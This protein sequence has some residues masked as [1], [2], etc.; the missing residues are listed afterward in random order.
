MEHV[1]NVFVKFATRVFLQFTSKF[2]SS[3]SLVRNLISSVQ[4]NIFASMTFWSGVKTDRCSVPLGEL[5]KWCPTE[6]R[7]PPNFILLSLTVI[8]LLCF[9]R[10]N[11]FVIFSIQNINLTK[12]NFIEQFIKFEHWYFF[13]ITSPCFSP[14]AACMRLIHL[15]GVTFFK[16]ILINVI[17]KFFFFLNV[18]LCY[19]Y[20]RVK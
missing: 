15:E 16:N 12:L 17:W 14:F 1:A 6:A 11:N 3:C 9:W 10:N 5:S 4:I 20:L 18:R 8:H 13:G 2:R 19:I 7:A